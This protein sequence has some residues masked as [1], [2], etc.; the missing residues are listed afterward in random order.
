MDADGILS[1]QSLENIIQRQTVEALKFQIQSLGDD[2]QELIRLRFVGDLTY[3]EIAQ[4][5]GRKEDAVRKSLNRILNK[6]YERMETDH[7]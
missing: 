1:D 2:E 7:A 6:L 4:F 5:L 3:L